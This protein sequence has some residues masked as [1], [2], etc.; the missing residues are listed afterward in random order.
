MYQ[1]LLDRVCP[2]F[3]PGV[4]VCD[5][6]QRLLDVGETVVVTA[7]FEQRQRSSGNSLQLIRRA[8]A[9]LEPHPCRDR[10]RQSAWGLVSGSIST[11]SRGGGHRGGSS[12]VDQFESTRELY[13][14]MDVEAVG[15][16]Q[17]ERPLEQPCGGV[18]VAQEPV[19]TPASDRETKLR[20]HRGNRCRPTGSGN[21][22]IL[23]R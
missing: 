23:P 3:E 12:D 5:P 15:A 2:I 16:G 20:P 8:L 14:E 21:G 1:R 9:C 18:E 10:A 4:H 13:L 6:S 17:R 22:A 7:L 11:H 19:R